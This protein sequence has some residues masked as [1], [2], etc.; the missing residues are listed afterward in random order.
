MHRNFE[1]KC[2][3]KNCHFSYNNPSKLHSHITLI[4]GQQYDR[5]AETQNFTCP[6][7]PKQYSSNWKLNHHREK[8]HSDKQ[9]AC[10]FSGCRYSYDRE[11][12]LKAHQ[13]KYHE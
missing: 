2:E 9:F 3:Y 11:K 6:E 4:H 13:K 10:D 7:C 12:Y 8:C 5:D 1:Y